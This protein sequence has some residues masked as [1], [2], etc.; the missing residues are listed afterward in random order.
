MILFYSIILLLWIFLFT[1]SQERCDTKT[2]YLH[3]L[4]NYCKQKVEMK[5]V[6]IFFVWISH[7][8]LFL[9]SFK[10]QINIL[11]NTK[12]T[13]NIFEW[14]CILFFKIK[15]HVHSH[16][17]RIEKNMF[18]KLALA[19]YNMKHTNNKWNSFWGTKYFTLI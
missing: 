5:I 1:K 2:W 9:F 6:L 10:Y 14:F 13:C 16:I 4:A 12:Y 8:V 19:I 15:Y 11:V 3:T 7:F 18:F 17:S